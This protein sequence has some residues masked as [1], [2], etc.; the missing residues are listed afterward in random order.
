M[1][2]ATPAPH[3]LVTGGGRGIGRATALA[4]ARTGA[5]V[6]VAA[7]SAS[8]LESVAA[9]IEALG[10][11]AYVEAVDVTDADAVQQMV[12][13]C[14]GRGG[15]DICVNS[16]GSN[17]TGPTVDL[18]PADF[19]FVMDVNVRGTFLVC[20]AVGGAM[21]EAGRGGRIVN[22]SSQMGVVG[23]P[24]R[25]AYCASKHAVNG[26][27]KALGVEWAPHGI[28]VNAVSPTFIETPLTAPMLA[29]PDFRAEVIRRIPMGRIGEVGEVAAAIVFLASAEAALITGAIVPVD[30]GWVA[31]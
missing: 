2:A 28:T 24:G 31:W 4:L 16:A 3:A 10:G 30:G 8:D 21:L 14:A 11:T 19:D 20:Q 22:V 5:R 26:L 15:L 18:S 12:A 1:S 27:T 25:A 13:A 29:D 7:R 6:T 17:R 23:Y 9:E